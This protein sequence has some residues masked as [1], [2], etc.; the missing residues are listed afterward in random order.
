MWILH[1]LPDGFILFV[2]YAVLALGAGLTAAS[3]LIKYIPGISAYK[4]PMRIAGVILLIC[5]VYFYGGYST[6]MQWRAR[7]AEMEEKVKVVV[8]K[9]VVVNTK[10]QTKVVEKI[11]LVKEREKGQVQYIEKEVV[12]YNDKC[13]IP[14]EFINVVNEAAV[15]PYGGKNE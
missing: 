14:K 3:Y 13:T 11:K 8:K 1:F 2:V 6:E 5:G 15:S 12:K 4:L 9:Q 7:V 10:I